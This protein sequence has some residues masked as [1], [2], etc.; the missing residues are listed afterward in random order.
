MSSLESVI[1]LAGGLVT[2]KNCPAAV[3]DLHLLIVTA[4]LESLGTF[5][6]TIRERYSCKSHVSIALVHS[7]SFACKVR[8]IDKDE[9]IILVP[10][11]VPARLRV[12]ARLL[13]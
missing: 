3:S 2:P 7:P 11:G 12:L 1:R 8:R 6:S 4:N 13:L 5:Y 10:I 9:Y